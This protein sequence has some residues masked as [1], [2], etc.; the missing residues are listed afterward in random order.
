MSRNQSRSDNSLSGEDG[1]TSSD[2][3]YTTCVR[4]RVCALPAVR[5]CV[6]GGVNDG[7]VRATGE[8]AGPV[9]AGHA[10]RRQAWRRRGGSA[11][12]DRPVHQ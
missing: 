6:D 4:R 2:C 9:R 8:P 12:Q 7:S 11:T 10:T 3:G 5:E 1:R